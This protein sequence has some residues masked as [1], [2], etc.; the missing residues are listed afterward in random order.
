MLCLLLG[1]FF[2][3]FSGKRVFI[4]NL[5][6]RAVAESGIGA[7]EVAEAPANEGIGVEDMDARRVKVSVFP[8]SQFCL[9]SF[10][11]CTGHA[12]IGIIG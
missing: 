3:H 7:E 1:I 4:A 6:K 12:R 11:L 5:K 2:T 8:F 10:V 9:C